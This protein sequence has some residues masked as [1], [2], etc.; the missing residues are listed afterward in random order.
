MLTDAERAALIAE[1][2]SYIGTPFRHRG[3][4]RRCIDCLGLVV[5]SF[6]AIGYDIR[7]RKSYGKFPQR[8]G[9]REEL[10]AR[11]G[12]PVDT[13]QVGDVVSMRWHDEGG[14]PMVNHVG[15]LTDYL[16]GGFGLIHALASERRVVEHRLAGPWPG[17]IVEGFRL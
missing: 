7:D 8:D 14:V 2:R 17:R 13:L 16:H 6:A 11:F 4:S 15:I 9:L 3:R 10:I 5:L 1:A 12:Q